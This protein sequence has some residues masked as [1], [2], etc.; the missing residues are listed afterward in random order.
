MNASERAVLQR[1]FHKTKGLFQ[2]RTQSEDWAENIID[3]SKELKTPREWKHFY[4]WLANPNKYDEEATEK[5]VIDN[6]M[7]EIESY[8]KHMVVETYQNGPCETIIHVTN[9]TL[10]S[11]QDDEKV[12]E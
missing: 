5:L 8:P 9:P 4:A 1:C 10:Y 2:R 6:T 7:T 3:G 12:A 11:Q